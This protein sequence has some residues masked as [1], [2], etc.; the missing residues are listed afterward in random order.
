MMYLSFSLKQGTDHIKYF[1]AKTIQFNFCIA[2]LSGA[3]A[4]NVSSGLR[5]LSSWHFIHSTDRKRKDVQFY[6]EHGFM[7]VASNLQATFY[8]VEAAQTWNLCILSFRN[9]V[10]QSCLKL[11]TFTRFGIKNR[12]L[13]ESFIHP[14]QGQGS[15]LVQPYPRW[16]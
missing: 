11:M 7:Y 2:S 15:S 9:D 1:S 16:H 10:Q 4:V 14:H 8:I 12:L 5:P 13:L 3:T 6:L